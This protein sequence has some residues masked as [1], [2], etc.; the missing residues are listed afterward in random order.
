MYEYKHRLCKSYID[1][2]DNEL[3]KL[4]NLTQ[5]ELNYIKNYQLY[6]RLAGEMSEKE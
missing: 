5:E 6:Y 3:S 4:Y 1:N 2:I